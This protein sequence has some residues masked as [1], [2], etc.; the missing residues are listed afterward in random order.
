MICRFVYATT[1]RKAL[2]LEFFV[3]DFTDLKSGKPLFRTGSQGRDRDKTE[4]AVL[5]AVFKQVKRAFK[6]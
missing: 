1:S 3:I 2:N 5:D 6:P 4:D